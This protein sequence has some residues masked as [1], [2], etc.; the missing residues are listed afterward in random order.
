MK[1]ALTRLILP[2]VGAFLLIDLGL[3]FWLGKASHA[4]LTVTDYCI[5]IVDGVT[6]WTGRAVW[7]IGA[8]IGLVIA[9][10]R[11]RTPRFL[12]RDEVIKVVSRVGPRL[13]QRRAVS[14]PVLIALVVLVP[15]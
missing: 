9:V 7:G 12:E 14:V 4:T 6:A 5:A 3:A 8:L 15:V 11:G 10:R 2:S 13:L 1:G